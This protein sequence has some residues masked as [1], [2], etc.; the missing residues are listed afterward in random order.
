MSTLWTSVEIPVSGRIQPHSSRNQGGLS[1]KRL[2]SASAELDG[3]G[4]RLVRQV[5]GKDEIPRARLQG[6]FSLPDE[7]NRRV[8][9]GSAIGA[10]RPIVDTTEVVIRPEQEAPDG[11]LDFHV[12]DRGCGL[13]RCR[14]WRFLTSLGRLYQR[15]FGLW[16]F[17]SGRSRTWCLSFRRR[18]GLVRR[19]FHEG[20]WWRDY[21]LD[22]F[23]DA[24]RRRWHLE[25]RRLHHTLRTCSQAARDCHCE[26]WQHKAR[27]RHAASHTRSY[28]CGRNIVNVVPVPGVD[29]TSIS[30]SCI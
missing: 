14:S 19:L 28:A 15:R 13:Q 3:E 26:H 30:P 29:S 9:L 5:P 20:D 8:V 12:F 27:T 1:D 23:D 21:G 16:G 7:P 18:N 24:R 22:R 6:F 11:P 17:W 2:G 4:E 25:P 10:Q